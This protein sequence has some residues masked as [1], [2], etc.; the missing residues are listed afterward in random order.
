MVL[1][2]SSIREPHH[3]VNGLT[4][5]Y[6]SGIYQCYWWLRVTYKTYV[7]TSVQPLLEKLN[8]SLNRPGSRL[9]GLTLLGDL[10]RKQPPWVH[11]ISRSAL[12]LSLLRCLKVLILIHILDT[13]ILIL[14]QSRKQDYNPLFQLTLVVLSIVLVDISNTFTYIFIIILPC[15][16][17]R[18]I[19]SMQDFNCKSF[20]YVAKM[21]IVEGE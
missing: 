5:L 14:I 13:V 3:K 6:I 17:W 1:L 15:F 10:I 20:S 2:L 7:V 18:N 11:H 8:E 9:A 16:Y 21:A 19:P 4:L 12:L